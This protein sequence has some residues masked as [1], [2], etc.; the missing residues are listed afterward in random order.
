MTATLYYSPKFIRPIVPCALAQHFKLDVKCVDIADVEKE[1]SKEFPLQL[2]P[3]FVDESGWELSEE[4]AINNYFIKT[5]A[6]DENEVKSLLG[7]CHKTESEVLRWESL[8][9]S[10]FLNREIDVVGPFIGLLPYNAE[11]VAA[12]EKKLAIFLDIYEK[13]LTKN[14]GFL[15]GDHI[16]LADLSTAGCFFLGFNFYNDPAWRAQYPTITAWYE[17]VTKS[18]YVADFFKDKKFLAKK[19]APPS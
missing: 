17:N 4:I 5:G 3:T 6:K 14:N 1:F 10:D 11:A 12:A 8:A 13:Q 15:V 19:P 18:P 9:V 2:V 7:W 16:T